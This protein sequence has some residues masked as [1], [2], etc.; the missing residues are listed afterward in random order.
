VK[1]CIWVTSVKIST[2]KW[3]IYQD[4]YFL[5]LLCW[6]ENM[7]N[8]SNCETFASFTVML[9]WRYRVSYF[10]TPL[11]FWEAFCNYPTSVHVYVQC[12]CCFSFSEN[13]SWGRKSLE[14]SL[15][16]TACAT[17]YFTVARCDLDFTCKASFVEFNIL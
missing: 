11:R 10:C 12:V 5:R 8:V 13:G 7:W 16:D 15:I 6:Q 17:R 3:D 14:I 1:T 9:L 2:G 4:S